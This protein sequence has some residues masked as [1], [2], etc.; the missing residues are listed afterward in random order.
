MDA[1]VFRLFRLWR[2]AK[3]T[4]MKLKIIIPLLALTCVLFAAE[5]NRPNQAQPPAGA[6]LQRGRYLVERVG[7]CGEC[8]SPRN[9]KGEYDRSQWLQG[10]LIDYKPTRPMPF[11]AIAPPIAGLPS[12]AKD[13]AAVKFLETGTN[14]MGKTALPPM[15]QFR[16]NHDDAMAVVAYL[17]SLKR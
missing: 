1:D 15:P 6:N 7:M 11:A 10:E 16:F 3:K 5:T 14:A 8:H 12:Y 9:D 2:L 17:R 13:E 4:R